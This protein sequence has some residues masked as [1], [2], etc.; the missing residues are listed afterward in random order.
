MIA[1]N[2]TPIQNN[3]NFVIMILWNYFITWCDNDFTRWNNIISTWGQDAVKV[4]LKDMDTK[5]ANQIIDYIN[6]LND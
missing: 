3:F 4:G 1:I 6:N 5:L 2:Q